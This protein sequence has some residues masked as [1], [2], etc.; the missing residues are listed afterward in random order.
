MYELSLLKEWSFREKFQLL[1]RTIEEKLNSRGETTI[2]ISVVIRAVWSVP[3]Q[4]FLGTE[5]DIED[6]IKEIEAYGFECLEF[7]PKWGTVLPEY[8]IEFRR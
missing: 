1:E 5:E 4:R 6:A 3:E 2:T 8:N 7:Y